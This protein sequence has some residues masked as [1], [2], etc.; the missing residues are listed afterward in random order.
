MKKY[1]LSAIILMFLTSCSKEDSYLNSNTSSIHSRSMN[2][3]SSLRDDAIGMIKSNAKFDSKCNLRGLSTF[4][5]ENVSFYNHTYTKWLTAR[6]GITG[7][8][9]G[10]GVFIDRWYSGLI[11]RNAQ[12]WTFY[13]T[14]TDRDLPKYG[15]WTFY[16]SNKVGAGKTR[17]L[18]VNQKDP[19]HDAS[20]RVVRVSLYVN[21]SNYVFEFIP[22][23]IR[24]DC[25]QPRGVIVNTATGRM[26]QIDSKGN[27]VTNVV[28]GDFYD[29][30]K[31]HSYSND[32]LWEAA[33]R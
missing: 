31:L 11:W 9:E 22:T 28:L 13:P 29:A 5:H 25:S 2:D 18:A 6:A 30:H 17:Y 1:L 27:D 23:E 8:W 3:Y 24:K 15:G 26:L 16:V 14:V 21:P 12:Q 33:P 20:M 10:A 32:Y 19:I 7:T 4:M